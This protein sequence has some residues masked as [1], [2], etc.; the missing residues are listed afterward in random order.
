[1]LVPARFFISPY[2][3]VQ[4]CLTTCTHARHRFRCADQ[5]R[6]GPQEQC[7]AAPSRRP[8]SLLIV[9]EWCWCLDNVSADSG[10][11]VPL[12]VS[13]QQ[14]MCFMIAYLLSFHASNTWLYVPQN[15]D[16]ITISTSPQPTAIGTFSNSVQLVDDD[17]LTKSRWRIRSSMLLG[18]SHGI[19]YG[20]D[21][22]G[23]VYM[24][25]LL[26]KKIGKLGNVAQFFL[27]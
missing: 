24:S 4:A 22:W 6:R 8:T 3:R 7:R 14:C 9:R 19:L 16:R 1:M 25:E 18:G 10:Q 13:L 21:W 12:S 27:Y 17:H 5:L 23:I 26:L 20:R 11:H 2:G 15:M